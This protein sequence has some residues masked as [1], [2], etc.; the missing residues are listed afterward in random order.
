M[1]SEEV[2][3]WRIR[4]KVVVDATM[5]VVIKTEDKIIISRTRR[6][7]ASIISKIAE[8][9][10]NSSNSINN[11]RLLRTISNAAINYVIILT[12]VPTLSK[13]CN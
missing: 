11:R 13:K 2:R 5:E 7:K 3:K 6:A 4:D 8:K 1:S 12:W 9:R 10:A